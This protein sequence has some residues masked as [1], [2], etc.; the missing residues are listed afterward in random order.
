MT[1]TIEKIAQSLGSSSRKAGGFMATCPCHD[2]GKASL[3]IDEKDG[4]LLFKCM[5]GCEQSDVF[6]EIKR[7]GYLPELDRKPKPPKV[8]KKFVAAYDYTDESGNV[9]FQ[10]VRYE[11]KGFSQRRTD[12]NGGHIYNLDGVTLTIYNLPEIIPSPWCA[13]TEGEKDADNLKGIGIPATTAPMGAGKWKPEYNRYFAGKKVVIFSDNDVPGQ[14]HEHMV[15]M[16][17]SGIAAQI[18]LVILPDLPPKGD[19][20]D[21]LLIPGNDR[22]KL[23]EIIKATAEWTPQAIPTPALVAEKPLQDNV[24]PPENQEPEPVRQWP[25]LDPAALPGIVGE[26]VTEATRQSE[27]DPAAVLFT[28]LTACAVEFGAYPHLFVGDSRHHARVN[29]IIVGE[30][31]KARKG[32]S[33]GPVKRVFAALEGKAQHSP[34]P[35][36]S[37]EG[38]VYAVRDEVREWQ[39]DR[40]SK[41]GE[42]VVTDPGVTDKRLFILDEEF[43]NALHSTKR[44]GNTLSAIIRGLYDDGNAAPLTKTTRTRTT[45]AHVGII[46]HITHG[47]LNTLLTQTE[48]LNGFGNR[49]LWGCARRQ[50]VVAFPSALSDGFLTRMRDLIA[51]RRAESA[52]VG[53]MVWG[54]GA[55]ELYEAEYPDLSRAHGGVAGCM[56]GRGEAMTV[57]LA[58]IYALLAGH[59]ALHVEDLQ[60]ALAA[61]K[62]CR[63]SALYLFGDTPA[64][65]RVTKIMSALE[66]GPMSRQEIREGI[67]SRHITRQE[68]DDLLNQMESDRLITL[69]TV[70]TSG[71]PETRISK[72]LCALSALSSLSTPEPYQHPPLK[73]HK[74]HKAQ[75]ISENYDFTPPPLQPVTYTEED[76]DFGEAA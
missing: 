76:F 65:R 37:G 73:E 41:V 35:L 11:P 53:C 20:S 34:G 68:L 67:F 1:M 51:E 69:E 29:A 2:D 66:D 42:W 12:G 32:T 72:Y 40:K 43:A 75:D 63:D 38:L 74:E 15:A 70:P 46:S 59:K 21:W 48:Q 71:R 3:S 39:I 50:G 4:K 36:S 23:M 25:R 27:A 10:C 56:V 49:F 33:A 7:R 16:A 47:E 55:R 26:F 13:I 18:K 24:V 57:R 6:A 31:S 22:A 28:F 54:P 52:S 9:V 5:A 61:W 58:M 62:Y 8:S 44:E 30:S 17:L 60:A 19:V 14:K 64:D 45:G